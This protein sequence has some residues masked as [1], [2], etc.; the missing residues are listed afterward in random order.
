M[1]SQQTMVNW[2]KD[3]VYKWI[4]MDGMYG[5]QCV[6]LTMAYIKNFADFQMYGN[7]IDYLTNPIPPGWKRYYKGDAE[8]AP[9]DIAIWHWGNWDKFGH[10]GIVIDVDDDIITSVEQNVD[11]TPERGGMA[12]IISRDD[13]YLAGFIRPSYDSSEE[14]NRI[15]EEGSFI[16][17]VPSI[18]VRNKPSKLGKIVSVYH[19]GEQVFYDSYVIKEG[20]VWISYI[21]YLGERH[22]MAIGTHNGSQRT[23]C[24]GDFE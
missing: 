19:K 2:A 24:W 17:S 3:N 5:A 16:V 4:D 21:S 8:I 20:F 18:N 12:R 15:D 7:A 14:W 22:Y 11:G 6:D 10:V 9:G 23:S 1:T 13:T